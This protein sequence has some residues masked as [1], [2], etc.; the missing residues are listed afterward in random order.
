MSYLRMWRDET[1][2][3]KLAQVAGIVVC[4]AGLLAFFG[5]ICALPALKTF[6]SAGLKMAPATATAFACEG[7]ALWLLTRPRPSSEIPAC[8]VPWPA[9]LLSV[10][11]LALGAARLLEAAAGRRWHLDL[12][13]FNEPEGTPN[14]AEMAPATAL[15]FVLLGAA[16]LFQ[17]SRRGFPAFQMF[18]FAAGFVGWLGFCHFLYGGGPLFPYSH[19]AIQ[20]AGAF[21][22]L[23]L[24]LFC[25]R[26]D[27]GL[28]ALLLSRSPGGSIA[29]RLAPAALFFPVALGW[30]LLGTNQLQNY[31]LQGVL[32]LFALGN[33]LVF[34]GL[35]W[36][37]AAR[38]D[39]RD[40]EAQLSEA[41][42]DQLAAIVA[43][44]DQA[45]L[46]LDLQGRITSWNRGAEKLYGYS[47]E[48]MLGQPVFRLVPQEKVAEEERLLAA[49]SREEAVDHLETVRLRKDGT[50]V[51]VSVTTSLLRDK[52][53]RLIGVSKIATDLTTRKLAEKRLEGQLA[54]M[55]LLSQTTRA[56]AERLDL[57]SIFRVVLTRLEEHLPIDFGLICLYEP[58]ADSLTINT[59]GSKG[60]ALADLAGLKEQNLLRIDQNG[61]GRCVRGELV[62]ERDISHSQ[63]DFPQRLAR[64][65]LRSLVIAPLLV[66][67]RVFGV[68]V[69]ARLETEAFTSTDCEFLRQLS[70][71][72]ALAAHNAE[73]FHALERAYDDLRLTQN[74]VLQQERLKA[75]GE[76]ASG[77]AHDINNAIS[78]V[79]LY[80]QS[81]LEKET[82]LSPRA[83]DYL[84]TIRDAIDDVAATVA[85]MREFYRRQEPELAQGPVDLNRMVEQVLNLTRARWSDLPQERGFVIAAQ[86][87]L[88]SDLPPVLGVEGEIREALTN[89]VL[90]AADAMPEGGQLT[91]RTRVLPAAAGNGN[92]A[93]KQRVSL[94]VCDTGVGMSEETRKRCLEP[95]FTTKGER[96]SGLGLAMVYGVAERHDA[97]LEI[98]SQLGRGTTMRLIFPAV[99]GVSASLVT[100]APA[101]ARPPRRRIL[102]V[103]DD[104]VLLKSLG[105]TLESDGHAITLAH[106]GQAGLDAFFAADKAQKPFEVVITDLGM[107]YVDGRKLARKIK[108]HS[109]NTPILLLTGWGRRLAGDDAIP[110]FVDQVLG[111]PPRLR[112]LRQA[113]VALAPRRDPGET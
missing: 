10:V 96:G 113:L 15:N 59:L 102:V 80:T 52:E 54:R 92:S 106:G 111:K 104:P 38:L 11:A 75:L 8:S 58:K 14:R 9:K 29:R 53:N 95:F 68:L 35:I 76:M 74:A 82:N 105:D 12:L 1:A 36:S 42:R 66:E 86:R 69:T 57:G 19:M 85:R 51:H 6:F 112:E 73:L 50:P 63:F 28:M 107:P 103:D 60:A 39:R 4:A 22:V 27:A 41:A 101:E 40:A 89:L 25:S 70:E 99:A 17:R 2:S 32:A 55:A 87:E 94:E 79:A 13:W 78:P 7:A 91:L 98:E 34:G 67:S 62:Y 47:A 84:Q 64:A 71:Q 43:T 44:T 110:S 65:G 31:G 90:N 88:A 45:V 72:V 20:S 97:E 5:W 24:G 61:L 108:E 30:L 37:T 33:V 81:L 100:V 77:I 93:E 49:M 26:P 83:R 18:V 46:S 21:L 109:P 3:R 48:Q 56:I 16:L 23:G